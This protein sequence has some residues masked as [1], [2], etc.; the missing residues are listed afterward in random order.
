MRYDRILAIAL[1]A[2]GALLG[3]A[4]GDDAERKRWTRPVRSSSE[5]ESDE[6]QFADLDRRAREYGLTVCGEGD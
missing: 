5:I 3:A 1:A 4:C 6:D 2:A